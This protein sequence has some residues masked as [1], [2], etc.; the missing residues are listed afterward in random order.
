MK[1]NDS[2]KDKG[3]GKLKMGKITEPVLV[4]DS[5]SENIKLEDLVCPASTRK[6]VSF[7]KCDMTRETFT[8]TMLYNPQE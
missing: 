4:A 2:L 6:V 8:E 3:K 7:Q 1:K 5:N